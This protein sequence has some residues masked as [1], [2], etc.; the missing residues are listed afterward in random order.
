MIDDKR[1]DIIC[2]RHAPA[3]FWAEAQVKT[4]SPAMLAPCLSLSHNSPRLI[5][6]RHSIDWRDVWHLTAR[7]DG[8]SGAIRFAGP[9]RRAR[10]IRGFQ[11]K[12]NGRPCQGGASL[13]RPLS[14]AL[15]G[16]C[17]RIWCRS[18][19]RVRAMTRHVMRFLPAQVEGT[20]TNRAGRAWAV[21]FDGCSSELS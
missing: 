16:V 20:L 3:C 6:Y 5:C 17:R 8:C 1:P 12:P 4:R 14:H 11:K 13:G 9:R 15:Q 19:N 10:G 2:N 18:R 7:P 21:L